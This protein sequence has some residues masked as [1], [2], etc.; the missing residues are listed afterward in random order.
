MVYSTEKYLEKHYSQMKK[1][2][3]FMRLIR[4]QYSAGFIG[5]M[6][7]MVGASCVAWVAPILK[8][9][10]EEDS[11]VPMT[12]S[13]SSW[14]VS[15]IEVG[16]FFTPTIAG[17]LADK[18]G[19]KPCIN[20]SVLLYFISWLLIIFVYSVPA[21]YLARILQGMGLGIT[22][23][24]VPM[25]LGEIA[26]T[27]IRGA[28]TTWF[29]TMFHVG[30][31][32][33]YCIGP[34]F[35][36][37]TVAYASIALPVIFFIAFMCQPESPYYYLMKNKD[38]KALDSLKLLRGN[39][40][41]EKLE[42]ELSEMKATIEGDKSR[43]NSWKDVVSTPA[44]RKALFL[45]VVVTVTKALSGFLAILSYA[46]EAFRAAEQS[47]LSP[48]QYTILIGIL[49][50]LVAIL[51]TQFVDSLGRRPLI[52]MSSFGSGICNILVGTY[53]YLD[54][55]TSVDV[56]SYGWF[57]FVSF[58]LFSFFFSFGLGPVVLTLQSELF[59]SNT[60]GIASSLCALSFTISSFLCLKFYQ[61]IIDNIGIYMNY[62]LFGI[63]CFIGL[64]IS[65]FTLPE[66]KGKTFAEIQLQLSSEQKR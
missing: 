30:L 36:Y 1:R 38:S 47:F 23:T 55:K 57:V 50:S 22:F 35:S 24:I 3:M 62:W 9:L 8:I 52:L 25:Y 53:Y 14:M 19:R 46:T 7:V 21:L 17:I 20:F 4:N 54:S 37:E 15:L 28:L 44:D 29:Q 63:F 32:Y 27:R 56:S 58:A 51:S 39:E 18:C 65:F 48:D 12:S 42:E 41:A 6:S 59:P 45:V 10:Q 40:S 13:Q 11:P 66:T 31:V 34:Y 43:S 5:S 16:P 33:E 60:R 61:V 49:M 64:I 26:E 2:A